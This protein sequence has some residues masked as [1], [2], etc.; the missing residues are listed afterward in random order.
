MAVENLPEPETR[1]FE[2]PVSSELPVKRWWGTETLSHDSSAIQMDRM[3]D[4]APL[5]LDH[6]P[7][8][9]IGVIESARVGDDKRLYATVRFSKSPKADE[10][11]NDVVDGI[12]KN[13]SIGYR[14]E[15]MKETGKDSYTATRW[16]PFEVSVTSIPADN[17]VGFGRAQGSDDFDPRDIFINDRSSNMLDQN[18][19]S[20]DV[21]TGAATVDETRDLQ[22]PE[23]KIDLES[24]RSEAAAAERTRVSNIQELARKANIEDVV[25]R[26]LIDDGVSWED[27]RTA[28]LNAWSA[29][30]DASATPSRTTYEM[31]RTAAD[32]ASEAMQVAL[33]ARCG[34]AKEEDMQGNEMIGMRM[35][36]MARMCL[37]TAGVNT[38]GMSYDTMANTVLRSGQQTTSDFPVLLEN[39]MHKVLLAAYQTAP[40]MWRSIA[41]TGSVSDFRPWKRLRT[42]TLPNLTRVNEAG[43]LTNMPI[44]DAIMEPIQ[45]YRWG[46]IISITPET[47]VND[48]FD[49]IA[50][51][52]QALGRAA[53]RTVE[54]SVFN[55]LAAN[56][57][58]HSDGIPLFDARH[59]NID[60]T[61]SEISVSS[62]DRGRV[63]MAK[64]M[65]INNND[66]LSLRPSMLL[67]PIE[68]GGLARVVTGSSYDPSQDA[69]LLVPSRINGLINQVL[70][71]NR[72]NGCWYLMCSPGDAPALEVVF[73][74]GNQN[75]RI[76]QEESFRTK[77]ISWSIELAFGVGVVDYKG[78]WRSGL[79]TSIQMPAD[80]EVIGDDAPRHAKAKA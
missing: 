54:V 41:K 56:P 60:P 50:N 16:L 61:A 49:W 34:L 69:R 57:V 78:I 53:A 71:S 4:G 14:I 65:D 23:K 1:R 3:R 18:E 12:R 67:C 68:D 25:V 29:K 45:A 28:M 32:K 66:F 64:Q 24:I 63:Q 9:Q 5:L 37:E 59:N 19:N 20:T 62:I 74:D 10:V 51:Q 11:M 70:D 44:S 52:S 13:V 17:N 42:G 55:L 40:D 73:L 43:E 35:T 2:I 26:K 30:V 15:D 76:M 6:D 8:Q 27:A 22:K 38:R 77:G 7:S 80:V 58:M 46:N 47:I 79:P 39:T 33:L 36:D 75:P 31:G 48:D 21:G 72:V